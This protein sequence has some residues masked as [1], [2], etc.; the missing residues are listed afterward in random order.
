MWHTSFR[1]TSVVV[2]SN[3]Q[4]NKGTKVFCQCYVID[5]Y[6]YLCAE[7]TAYY[8]K[9][10]YWSP[11]VS[12]FFNTLDGELIAIDGLHPSGI[13][14]DPNLLRCVKIYRPWK[15]RNESQIWGRSNVF[16]ATPKIIFQK[17]WTWH[18]WSAPDFLRP[19][20]CSHSWF[21]CSQNSLTWKINGISNC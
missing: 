1:K 17:D 12:F 3:F 13:S 8:W 16:I 6:R 2:V 4:K 20:I 14:Y 5:I 18:Y 21:Y 19:K 10:R 15:V 11:D 9:H 7:T